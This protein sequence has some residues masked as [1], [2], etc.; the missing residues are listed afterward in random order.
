[1]RY[2]DRRERIVCEMLVKK[3]GSEVSPTAGQVVGGAKLVSVAETAMKISL[4]A[5]REENKMKDVSS[6]VRNIK[7][8]RSTKGFP[9][10]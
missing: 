6:W 4:P 5:T 3:F 9:L 8:L 1:M 7:T 10:R 2:V